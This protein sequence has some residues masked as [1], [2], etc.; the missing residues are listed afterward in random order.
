M[1]QAHFGFREPPFGITPDTSFFF[2]FSSYQ[3]ALNTLLVAVRTGEGFIKITGEVGTGK[4]LLCRKFLAS[5]GG[6]F[7]TAYIPNP[8]LEPRTLLMAVAD[9]LHIAVDAMADQHHLLKAL[10]MGLMNFAREGK[11]VV[12]CLDEAQ[13][14]PLETLE[15]LRLLTNLETEKRKLLQIVLFGQPELDDKLDQASIRQ[16]KQRISFHYRL[17]ELGR[18][19]LEAYVAHRLAIAGY[20]GGKLFTQ[21]AFGQLYRASGGVPRLVNILAHKA[22]LLAYGQGMNQ[23][24]ARHIRAA[25]ADTPA[26]RRLGWWRFVPGRVGRK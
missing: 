2:A 21:S 22:L 1:Y 16:L 25:V 11:R 14:M 26:A 13:A 3:E 23:V 20:A 18:A 17:G 4:T 6:D 15:A 10:T 9:D 8:Y 24:E 5:L 19:E 7:V 12:L